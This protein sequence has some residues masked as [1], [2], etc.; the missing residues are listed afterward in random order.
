MRCRGRKGR[1]GSNEVWE[2]QK[3]FEAQMRCRGLK[4]WEADRVWEAQMM[5]R[6]K[7]RCRR[8]RT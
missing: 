6:G 4:R 5:C 1:G 2:T 3:V 8:P 7:K